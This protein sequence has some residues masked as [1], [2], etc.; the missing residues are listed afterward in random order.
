MDAIPQFGGFGT[1][2]GAFV[3]F[4][5]GR[6]RGRVG[7]RV[8]APTTNQFAHYVSS[9][10]VATSRGLAGVIAHG[11]G[12]MGGSARFV[13]DRI[14]RGNSA[15]TGIGGSAGSGISPGPG[16][17]G[18]RRAFGRNTVAASVA[19]GTFVFG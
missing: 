11:M 14:F 17:R 13:G 18:R 10:G 4:G 3:G 6:N 16:I 2:L 8:T 1:G 12:K 5:G 15:T 19:A 7:R 9:Q